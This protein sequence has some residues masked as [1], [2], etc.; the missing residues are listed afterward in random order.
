MRRACVD[1]PYFALADFHNPPLVETVLSAQFDRLHSM[2]MV[3]LGLLWNRLR[4]RFPDSEEKPTLTP[5]IERFPD[6]LITGARVRFEAVE[7]SELPRLWLLNRGQ[8][9]MIQVQN[10]RFVKNWRKQTEADPYPHYEPVI[11]PAFE[12][13]FGE[14]EAFLAEEGLGKLN[15]NQ[16]E[17]TYVNHIVSGAG[18]QHFGEVDQLFTFWN[19][20]S[21]LPAVADAALH[22]R[23]LIPDE[24]GRPIGRLHIDIQPAFQASDN[25]PM[26]VVNLTARGQQGTGIQFFDIG[27]QW[28]VKS[29][30]Q[31]TTE[32]MHVIWGGK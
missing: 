24:N 1:F 21:P 30:E 10:D 23:L 29:F 16:C 13:D 19:K 5:V 2:R 22:L 9:E 14:F 11:K 20:E 25:R 6:P 4:R 12:R 3:H 17:V 31:L 15:V 28:I 32:N 8:N 26:Y 7:I 27:R 18:W